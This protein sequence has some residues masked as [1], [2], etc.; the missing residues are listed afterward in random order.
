MSSELW[1]FI[2][3]NIAVI[4]AGLSLI[5]VFLSA[6]MAYFYNIKHKDLDRFYKNAQDNMETLIEP[7]YFKLRDIEAIVDK[8]RKIEL[9]KE[10]FDSYNYNKINISRLG[11]RKLIDN[12]LKCE[13]AFKKIL[14]DDSEVLYQEVIVNIKQLK[15]IVDTDY[16]KLFE[17][18]YKDYNWY[19]KTV[20][21]NYIL[22]FLLKVSLFLQNT[23]YG[24][25]FLAYVFLTTF[26]ILS[27]FDFSFNVFRFSVLLLSFLFST[28]LYLLFGMYNSAFADTKQKR[29]TVDILREMIISFT[30]KVFRGVKVPFL[31]I[32]RGLKYIFIK[33]K[34]FIVSIISFFRND[35]TNS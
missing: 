17:V 33:L 1:E 35:Q 29:T 4:T 2:K 6:A 20:D 3:E 19:K 8:E 32:W 27:I 22:R 25:A 10:F 14:I 7:I 15:H 11:N 23:F 24:I 30:D 18:I 5:T 13:L 12:F 9:L 34:K 28:A 21:M 16:W 31:L 26:I